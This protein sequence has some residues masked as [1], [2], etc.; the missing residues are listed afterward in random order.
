[1]I[2]LYLAVY[3]SERDESL[4]HLYRDLLTPRFQL[5]MLSFK[6][7]RRA[8]LYLLG[9]L[10]LL[11]CIRDLGLRLDLHDIDFGKYNKPYF[12]HPLSFN[13]SYA[14]AYVV[15]AASTDYKVGI[16]IETIHPVNLQEVISFFTLAEKEKIFASPL[17]QVQF[18][19]I[20]TRKEAVLKAAGTGIAAVE[21]SL[22]DVCA[23]TVFYDG[24]VYYLKELTILPGHSI[25]L[26][27]DRL[28]SDALLYQFITF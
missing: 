10:L 22:F 9:K 4:C 18:F 14:D 5:R 12:H 27:T 1:M 15:C 17:P 20:W 7:K 16:D 2:Y 26:A 21:L 11:T 3:D 13:I 24:T 23:E 8:Q 6:D 28:I 19:N 25:H